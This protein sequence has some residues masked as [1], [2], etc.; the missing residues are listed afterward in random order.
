MNAIGKYA[1]MRRVGVHRYKH[2]S[3][4]DLNFRKKEFTEFALLKTPNTRHTVFFIR[5]FS[6]LYRVL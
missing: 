4:V 6:N 3:Y 5:S 1:N 2:L